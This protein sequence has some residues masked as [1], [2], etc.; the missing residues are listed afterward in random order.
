MEDWLSL[1]NALYLS[2]LILGALVTVMSTKYRNI[3]KELSELAEVLKSGYADQKL[4]KAEK[5]AVIR[6]ALDV[7]KA[8]L[9]MKWSFK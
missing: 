1:N 3:L 5:E 6:E 9:L 8:I 7:V 4:S 2:V